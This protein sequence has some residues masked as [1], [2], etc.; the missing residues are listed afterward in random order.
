MSLK[1][2]AIVTGLMVVAWT[3]PGL[4]AHARKHGS[5]A[6]SQEAQFVK[7]A[8]HGGSAEVALG[9]LAVQKA[10][11]QQVKD[12]G[13]R[14]I[15]DHGKAN[16]GLEHAARQQG[17]EV[18]QQPTKSQQDTYKRLS[19]LSGRE[20]DKQYMR[21]ML[22][23]HADDAAKFQHYT[24]TGPNDPVKDWASQTLGIINEHQ[25]MARNTAHDLGIDTETKGPTDTKRPHEL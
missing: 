16:E 7:E 6:N 25:E 4:A 2:M 17:L 11:N 9:K 10:E 14:M 22:T 5:A 13:Q 12:F 21:V 20:F 24:Q 19:R 3:A 18:P 1:G 23:D 15:D 8:G